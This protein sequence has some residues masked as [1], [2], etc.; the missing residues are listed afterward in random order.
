MDPSLESWD[1]CK[2]P[3]LRDM[4]E[5]FN[6]A[7]M[8]EFLETLHKIVTCYGQHA[9]SCS[10]YISFSTAFPFYLGV[11]FLTLNIRKRNFLF[12]L[13]VYPQGLRSGA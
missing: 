6:E 4:E 1:Y 3:C 9:N 10:P 13:L 7:L 12:K 11:S 8:S 5:D 2:F